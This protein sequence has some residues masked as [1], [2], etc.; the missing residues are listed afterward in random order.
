MNIEAVVPASTQ[1]T[2]TLPGYIVQNYTNFVEFMEEA[3][4]GQE[5]KGFGQDLLQNLLSY[6]DFSTYDKQ[7]RQFD[8]LK[9]DVGIGG[10][11]GS[12]GIE[13]LG[14]SEDYSVITD[15]SY[16][17]AL[18]DTST[19][20]FL[21]NADGFPLKNG[22][23]LVDDEVILYGERE[24][25][26]L[27]GLLRGASATTILP[28]FT[29]PGTY[30]KRT[31]ISRHIR[32][33]KV[34]NLSVLFMVSMLDT[35]H[36]TF[37]PGL[38]STR[39]HP[40]VT[41]SP[42]LRNIKDFYQAKGTKLGTKAFFKMLFGENDVQVRYP[43]DQMIKPSHSTWIQN[44]FLRSIPIPRTLCDPTVN[45]GIPS[46]IIG[47]EIL[48]RS[49]LDKKEKNV[50]GKAIADYVSTYMFED[51][52]QYEFSLVSDTI[53]GDFIAN[54]NTVLTR[55]LE[56]SFTAV[57][58]RADVSTVTVEST[59]GFPDSGL[60]FIGN[61]GITY[62][63]KSFNQFFGCVRAY[64]GVE[65]PHEIGT[66]VFGPYFIESTYVEDGETYVSRSWPMGLVSDV[67]IDDGGILH[68][69]QDQVTLNGPGRVDYREPILE[70]F[71]KKENYS[72][73]L[74]T[75][76][77]G[78]PFLPFIGNYTWG[79]SGVYFNDEYV[80]VS[81]SNLPDYPVGLFSKNDAVGP[82]LQGK[83]AI[84]IIPRRESIQPN[85]D[86]KH[87]GIGG[88][89]VFVDGV[90]AYSNVSEERLY[91]GR[92]ID[93]TILSEGEGYVTPTVLINDEPDD[94]VVGLDP[95]LGHVISITPTKDTG[96]SGEPS[97]KITS[98]ENGEILL[99]YDVYGRITSASIVNQGQYYYDTPRLI[100]TDRSGRGK[101]AALNCTVNGRGGLA[102]VD[103]SHSGID[104]N[105]STTVVTVA[106]IG[107]GATAVANIEYYEFNRWDVIEAAPNQFFD[108]GN[109]FLYPGVA[110][111]ERN[112]FAYIA[113]P[114][115]L[116]EQLKDDGY[117]HSPL[118]GWAFDGNPIYGPIGYRDAKTRESGLVR[119]K[120]GYRKFADRADMIPAN[121]TEPGLA[122]PNT[123][124]PRGTFIQDYYYD[125][126]PFSS[127]TVDGNDILDLYNGKVCNTPEFP[128][129][130]Y[131]DGVYCYFITVEADGEPAF[132]YIIGPTFKNKPISQRINVTDH[133]ELI[134]ITYKL[135]A[136]SATYDT[137]VIDFDFELIE[138]YRN[139]YLES[140]KEG[141]K[142]EV[143]DVSQGHVSGIQIEDG[144]PYNRVVGDYLYF[145]DTDTQGM[146]AVGRITHLWGED[147][148]KNQGVRNAT[149]TRLISHRQ[150]IDLRH[151]SNLHAELGASRRI[152]TI[153]PGTE[154]SYLL[155]PENLTPI[156]TG[157]FFVYTTDGVAWNGDIVRQNDWVIAKGFGSNVVWQNNRY[158][159]DGELVFIEGSRIYT[160]SG[161]EAVIESYE[162]Q[163]LI[164]HTD[165]PNLILAGDTFF[166]AK[167]YVVEILGTGVLD[168]QSTY[169]PYEL[170]DST[171]PE[172]GVNTYLGDFIPEEETNL[173]TGDLW[174]SEQTGR[175][176]IFYAGEWICTQPIGTRPL[177]G[178]SNKGIGTTE[179]TSEVVYHPQTYRTVTISTTA[180][181]FRTDGSNLIEG[182]LWWSQHTG[183]LYIFYNRVWA[184][185]DPNGSIAI[186]PFDAGGRDF[187]FT[188]DPGQ[189]MTGLK[190]IVSFRSP[191]SY[192][193]VLGADGRQYITIVE[194]DDDLDGD[195]VA[196]DPGRLVGRDVVV[197]LTENG[198][199]WWSPSGIGTGMMYI[200]YDGTWVIT[201]PVA[202]LSSIYAL[203]TS[204]PDGGGQF[205]GGNDGSGGGGGV[206]PL[207]ELPDQPI[208]YFRN[209]STFNVGD[210]IEFKVGAPGVEP[211]EKALILQK[212]PQN[213]LVVERGVEGTDAILIPD[214]TKTENLINYVYVVQTEVPH[215]LNDGDEIFIEGSR[216]DE[217]NG[218]KLIDRAGKVQLA[219]GE[220]IISGGEVTGITMFTGGA[221]YPQEVVVKFTGGG[222][223]GA[224]G[225]ADVDPV[226]GEILDV[227]ITNPGSGYTGAP[228]A[229]FGD[230]LPHDMFFLYTT[231]FY[232]YDDPIKYSHR[233]HGIQ[234]EAA[235][236]EVLTGGVGYQFIPPIIGS[237]P[238][239]IDRA[240]VNITTD[241][242]NDLG[243]DSVEIISGGNR[244]VNPTVIF[245]DEDAR[246]FGAEATV[247]VEGGQITGVTITNPG[248]GYMEPKL[249]F[250]EQDGK[251]IPI[252]DNI[253]SIRGFRVIDPGRALNAD[254]SLKPEILI[255]TRCIV[256][257]T[258]DS[259]GDFISGSTVYQG[260]DEHRLVTAE[261][262]EYQEDKQ[263]IVLRN[264][265]GNLKDNEILYQENTETAALV[266]KEG[267]ADCSIIVDAESAKIGRWYDDTSMVS[268]DLAVIQDSYYYQWFSYVIDSPLPI[269][270]YKTFLDKVIH[271]AGFQLFA[272]LRIKSEV[273]CIVSPDDFD[274]EIITDG[275]ILGPD[276]EQ[277]IYN[278]A[279]KTVMAENASDAF[280]Q[281][282]VDESILDGTTGSGPPPPISE[283]EPEPET[284]TPEPTPDTTPQ[285]PTP[286][287]EPEPTPQ[288]T[289]QPTPSP[290]YGGY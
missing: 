113:D 239:E 288:S 128:V 279:T 162:D 172:L 178:A 33:T 75:T 54:P 211:N 197:D 120:S 14:T 27:I 185:T 133:E 71:D 86:I 275:V 100:V 259:V 73:E 227:T 90:P 235:Y 249:L 121:G 265:D 201:N 174:W 196:D 68:T 195:G 24:G 200:R 110:S 125:N 225:L 45:Y 158:Y 198:T 84:H 132:P 53:E 101:G 154:P 91:Q 219:L 271:P 138:R 160:S 107:E 18:G 43:G 268:A 44:R 8:Y 283:P 102:T 78:Q 79:V 248:E 137:K 129:E 232:E 164:V 46:K 266:V 214:G 142:L 5:R 31:P 32:G 206:G 247:Q 180:P 4:S 222:G 29:N 49:Y 151:Y 126:R 92:I 65:S 130:V 20:I 82:G 289:P 237:Y 284:E 124:F 148:D 87:K 93:F 231:K 127:E 216:Y 273:S 171:P 260:S 72:D 285:S 173:K 167:K 6:R 1:V 262:V 123:A 169:D 263:V 13:V 204:A 209:T 251:Y 88:I 224:R 155:Y 3:T 267:Q 97:V 59:L 144:A 52:T 112:N 187:A 186:D 69:L 230:H 48:Y 192:A 85:D 243:I 165:T 244:Y 114:V 181:R 12:E 108:S 190:V 149:Q 122:P 105:P 7:I 170:E 42:L 81:S 221:K 67:R 168:E 2:S 103:V 106:P 136:P 66:K 256:S 276:G 77:S 94:V 282:A 118:I 163:I 145:D 218:R 140:T 56:S 213:G 226:T 61:E 241:P 250:V 80:F 290:G 19:R 146:G 193:P 182:D 76:D 254:R 96:Y 286:E 210:I 253:G 223:S 109:G 64:R 217:I 245:W 150:Q 280:L 60:I 15:Q 233:R 229:T 147:V 95:N 287:P 23:I 41:R 242:L 252:T 11:S 258:E 36:Q 58:S 202:T 40:D 188:T 135:D 115:L 143:S 215:G 62:T 166:D 139:P 26:I 35:I 25:N 55:S 194:T 39:F 264:V 208:L 272:D 21:T 22:V 234:G 191:E 63:S 278:T 270:K 141:I 238:E 37:V 176:Y 199:L 104:Y 74:A 28:S 179:S 98:G 212:L 16:E 236:A 175:L 89:G 111:T 152:G 205:P 99:Q 9:E 153:D 47:N 116:R 30:L 255:T 159:S 189:I 277:Y 10:V 207:P 281:V 17:I 269:L 119:Q 246:G 257:P 57:D 184:C 183:I 50:Y 134:P 274:N 38:S 70:S 51:E 157:D 220:G 34:Y 261:V 83:F 117:D 240:V 177:V 131:P 156:R 228:I 161:A 203:N